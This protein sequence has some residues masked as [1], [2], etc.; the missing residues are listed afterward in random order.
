MQS[1]KDS[2]KPSVCESYITFEKRTNPPLALQRT[3]PLSLIQKSWSIKE[4]LI[5][6]F[7]PEVRRRKESAEELPIYNQNSSV[8]IFIKKQ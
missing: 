1:K 7:T 5:S 4:L 8:L 2:K 3:M 6:F